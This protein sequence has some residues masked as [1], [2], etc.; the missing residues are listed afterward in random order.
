M[1]PFDIYRTESKGFR[2]SLADAISAM[3]YEAFRPGDIYPY[4]YGWTAGGCYRRARRMQARYERREARIM[5]PPKRE[6]M[7]VRSYTQA[8]ERVR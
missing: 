1:T 6:A 5:A 3:R 4:C 2:K 8:G 7:K